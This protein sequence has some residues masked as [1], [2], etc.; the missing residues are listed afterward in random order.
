MDGIKLRSLNPRVRSYRIA[1]IDGTFLFHLVSLK[2][3]IMRLFLFHNIF[4]RFFWGDIFS[5]FILFGC[6][7]RQWQTI[8]SSNIKNYDNIFFTSAIS[9]WNFYFFFFLWVYNLFAHKNYC[10]V[11]YC[12]DFI[13]FGR[14]FFGEFEMGGW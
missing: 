2:T 6:L 11:K 12:V 10:N 8:Q 9:E 13:G 4:Y 5:H 1:P 7:E 3:A 14:I